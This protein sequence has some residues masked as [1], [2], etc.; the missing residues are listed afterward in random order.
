MVG[1]SHAGDGGHH[2]LNAV[3]YYDEDSRVSNPS[4]NRY[5]SRLARIN[6][7]NS[8][9]ARFARS[10]ARWRGSCQLRS[11]DERRSIHRS[12]R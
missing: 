4:V 3:A 8:S 7:L 12:L 5:G 10:H 9:V 6:T 1:Q 2:A 11:S